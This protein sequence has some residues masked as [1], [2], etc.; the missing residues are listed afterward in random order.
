MVIHTRARGL[1]LQGL[2]GFLVLAAGCS[3][4]TSEASPF[5]NRVRTSSVPTLSLMASPTIVNEGATA[6]Y[7]VSASRVNSTSSTTVTYAMS[8]T[9]VRGTHYDLNGTFGKI[10]IPAGASSANVTLT[11]LNNNLNTGSEAATMALKSGTSYKLSTA[12]KASVTIANTPS[13]TPT[14]A[15]TGT[16]NPTATP[17]PAPTATPT[18]GASA[19]PTATPTATPAPTATPSASPRPTPAQEYWIATRTDGLPGTG[20]QADPYDGSSQGKFDAVMSRLQ[21]ILNP[22][23][24]LMGPGPFLTSV[25]HDWFVRS[26][27]VVSGDGMYGT[28]IQLT[29]SM[30][31]LRDVAVFRSDASYAADYITISNLT[32][33]SNWP[34]LSASA[35]MGVGGEKNCKVGAIMLCGSY[36][37]IDRVRS[38]NTY[39]SLANY[40]EDFAIFLVSPSSVDGTNDVI[41]YCRVEMPQGN[42]QA[43][44]GLAGWVWSEPMRIL[45]NSKV[46]GC[47]AVGVN[48]GL[49]TGKGFASGGVNFAHI[50]DCEIDGNTFTDCLGAAYIDTQSVDGLKVTNNT[51]IRGWLGVGLSSWVQPKQNIE[52]SGNNFQIQNRVL[53]GASYGMVVGYGPTTNLAVNNNTITFDTSGAGVNSFWGMGNSLLTDATVSNNTIGLAF[54]AVDNSAT[55]INITLFNNRTPAGVPVPGLGP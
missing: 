46:I 54:Y 21:W 38:I 24:H 40:Q 6:V 13:P 1:L 37:V 19:S 39:G 11:A 29:G 52:I 2:V 35:D 41:Q 16:P 18:P 20:T 42:H 27:W 10:T 53:N 48:N 43:P 45:T 9:A 22:G 34:Q 49:S 47:T 30:A 5:T 44:F 55:G 7:T 3:C 50:K 26:G 25:T 33:D 14:P 31:G 12:I 28:T 32:I 36:N 23:I 8:G 15:P 17:S 4:A 51:V